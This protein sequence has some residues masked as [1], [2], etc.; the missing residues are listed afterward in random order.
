MPPRRPHHLAPKLSYPEVYQQHSWTQ[1]IQKYVLLWALSHPVLA[2]AGISMMKRALHLPHFMHAPVSG[3]M[4]YHFCGGE[5]IE[6]AIQRFHTDL[7]RG[8]CAAF[9]Y[10]IEGVHALTGLEEFSHEL[11]KAIDAA[12][13]QYKKFVVVK[14]S[15]VIP[16]KT[17]Q[18]LSTHQS[19]TPTEQ[20]H[21]H[22]SQQALHNILEYAL[23]KSVSVLI[24]AE[25]S[26]VQPAIDHFV[27]QLM[28]QYNINYPTVYQTIQMYRHDRPAYLKSFLEQLS[29][30]NV[31]IG[32]KLVR[33]AYMEEENLHA[34]QRGIPSPIF[35]TKQQTDD[36]FDQAISTC[37]EFPT[38]VHLFLGTHNE[39]SIEQAYLQGKEKHLL[40]RVCFS[41]LF[42]MCD[43]ISYNL[44]KRGA[45][46]VKFV[47]YGPVQ[48]AIP[49][50]LRRAEE[51]SSA[52]KHAYLERLSLGKEIRRR[53][54]KTTAMH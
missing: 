1:L 22:L 41:Q 24:D 5:T 51:N 16:P 7:P 6:T 32:I 46:V 42:G 21:L 28:T 30:K 10:A 49:Y 27:E 25:H 17:L 19:L 11:L 36:A 31:H 33:G 45:N 8:M 29:Q 35:P 20:E 4:H 44:S 3:S 15:A 18:Q 38:P 53:M 37:L 52:S 43:E 13:A 50:L 2:K 47:P 39:Q 54:F 23:A 14:L 40:D 26:W 48:H 12:H 9:D 34:V